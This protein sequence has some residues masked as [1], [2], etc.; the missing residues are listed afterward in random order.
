MNH[1]VYAIRCLALV[2]VFARASLATAQGPCPEAICIEKRAKIDTVCHKVQALVYFEL[3]DGSLCYC[4][5]SCVE[6]RT[7]VATAPGESKEIH[8][9]KMGEKV[10]TLRKDG[11]WVPAEVTF[12]D[13][14]PYQSKPVPYSIYVLFEGGND[15]VVTPDHLF[16]TADKKLIRA[17]RL[18][19]TTVLM[20][21][22]L[23]P[24]KLQAII[25]GKAVGMF[26]N[27]AVGKWDTTQVDPDGHFINTKGIVS[28][29]F[30]LQSVGKP[31]LMNEDDFP[32]VGSSG[33]LTKNAEYLKA[34]KA[35][36][37]DR[38]QPVIKLA[39]DATFT[40]TLA[41]D[42]P[43]N[44]V[45][46]LPKEYE[47]PK[48]GTLAPLDDSVPYEVAEYLIRN[49]SVKFPDIE[50]HIDWYN[51]A[52]NAVAYKIGDQRHV[53]LYGGL[54]RHIAIKPEGAGLVL[55]HEIGHHHG[56]APRYT[57]SGNDWASCEGQADYWAALV[58]QRHVWW[59]PYAIEQT[60]K[61]GVQLY[62]LFAYGLRIG[63]LFEK[64]EDASAGPC[65]HPPAACRLATY[66]AAN[67]LDD[68]P[69]CA[70]DPPGVRGVGV[71]PEKVSAKDASPPDKDA[72]GCGTISQAKLVKK[73]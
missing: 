54:L 4:K 63:N 69:G 8:G 36:G 37:L 56:G 23:K 41:V 68:K 25:P 21:A 33:Y 67:R 65:S 71:V 39:A 3:P 15:L 1:Y 19:P 61:G 66:R 28:A 51:D 43:E 50:Y 48:P 31:E 44:H 60:E 38:V 42:I 53:T 10:L 7:L 52:V 47:Q 73:E 13:D 49:Y 57:G 29:D 72:C 55:A 62:N 30:Y 16:L 24:V 70:G 46:F 22:E 9:I 58:C 64:K 40:P 20:N 11:Q 32:Q 35:F 6:G 14:R 2:A 27:I 45:S 59:G 18:Q 26:T 17:D 34:A 12:T 5:C